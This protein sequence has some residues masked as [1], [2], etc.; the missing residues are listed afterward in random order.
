MSL[1][2]SIYG[3]VTIKGSVVAV[4]D[5]RLLTATDV[6]LVE[7]DILQGGTFEFSELSIQE[8]TLIIFAIGYQSQELHIDVTKDTLLLIRLE[9]LTSELT[10]VVIKEQR[11]EQFSLRKLRAVEGTSIYAGKK[12]EVVRME[13]M[14]G[15]KAAN[16]SREIYAQV[17]GLN[18]YEG[19]DG[20]L[21]L[22]IGGRGLDPNRT[23][24]FNTRQNGY[25]IS[26]DVLGYPESYFT[27]PAEALDE[28]QIVRGAASLQYGTQF[29]GLINFKTH[30]IPDSK[31][32]EI[33]TIQTLGSFGFLN[34]FNSIGLRNQKWTFQSYYNYKQGNGYRANSEFAAHN[35]FG[36]L[37]YEWNRRSSLK[38]EY[39]HFS[40]LAK[41][42]GGLTDTQFKKNPR[43]STR[44]RNWF[45]VN[46]NLY[47]VLFTHKF[48]SKSQLSVSLFALDASR[49][50]L[51]FRGNPIDLNGN[52]ITAFDEQ[53]SD[54]AYL[55][56]RD[57]IKGSF[58]NFG[59]EARFLKRYKV[60]KKRG[61]F[62][63]GSKYY[64]AKNLSIQG[65]GSN[66]T[67]ADFG[68]RT[69]QFPDYA[70]QSDFTFPNQ[71]LAIFSENILYINDRLSITPGVRL[72]HIITKS[73]GN[74]TN[75][76]YDNAGNAISTREFEDK[77]IF[78]RSF[79]LAGIGLGYR[80]TENFSAFANIS[81]NYRSV[82]F[83]DIRTVNPTF[84]IDPA[85]SDERGFTADMG[86]KGTLESSI[87]Y[88]LGIFGIRYNDRIG[89]ILND[90][91]NRVRK[92]IGNA[93]I[94]GLETLVEYDLMPD[95]SS[96]MFTIFSN[97]S[98]TDSR[99]IQSDENNVAGKK[100]EF[101]P[102]YNIKAGL[103]AGYKDFMT[104]L[105]WS[106]LSQQFTDAQ[107]S[108]IPE[109]GDSREGVI[110]PIPSYQVMDLSASYHFKKL[111]I[112]SG[113][114]NALNALYFTRRAT[115]YPGP[116]II[117]SDGR[118]FYVTIK[119]QFSKVK[120]P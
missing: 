27:P 34:S 90:R 46:W 31:S 18:I 117:P 66:G 92:N 74:Y 106:Y 112:S 11:D 59:L 114:N 5:N 26:A 64:K 96:T 4:E 49:Y 108:T 102:F 65:P 103:N 115:G 25:D 10:E 81:Q 109:S 73:Q 86:I 55:N 43:Q 110:G 22:A 68:F 21:Q 17:T 119:Y 61:V 38:L 120:K 13:N 97:I 87:T 118:N 3:Q 23:A 80:P 28:I 82:T 69:G 14:L 60:L 67:R 56:P 32:L 84:I 36:S 95:N 15:N 113:I 93:V 44:Q 71:N 6:Y 75:V 63:I 30:T 58:S 101:I 42:A 52:P 100:V 107:N 12:S 9:K 98:L 83:S 62:L 41:Q 39:T 29:G 35:A 24:N 47:N 76:I 51:G 1:S 70:N 99:Y 37:K 48:S 2:L 77:Q 104:S 33:N 111:V 8:Y 50:S 53:A 78:P 16:N 72:E 116:G 45:R 7:N 57:L 40:Y 19:S 89:I 54:G 79:I 88:D 20:G 105:Q 91:A 94:I 85:I